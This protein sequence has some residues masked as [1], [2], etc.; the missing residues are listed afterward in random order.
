VTDN[1][2]LRALK[3]LGMLENRLN[4]FSK[5]HQASDLFEVPI[6]TDRPPVFIRW[7]RPTDQLLSHY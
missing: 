3:S 5:S 2:L 4:V 7:N 6:E 1:S